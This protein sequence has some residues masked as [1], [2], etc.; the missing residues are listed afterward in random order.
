MDII[1]DTLD[2]EPVSN[3][4]CVESVQRCLC[5]YYFPSCNIETGEINPVCDDSCN[6]LFNNDDCLSLIT[7]AYQ[8]LMLYDISD[9]PDESC[10]QTY[11]PYRNPVSVSDDCEELQG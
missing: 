6:L 9:F 8:E 1:F 11:R 5:Y 3:S 2:T 7:L 4:Q 10:S